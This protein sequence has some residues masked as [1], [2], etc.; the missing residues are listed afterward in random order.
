MFF[1]LNVPIPNLQASGLTATA[2]QSKKGKQAAKQTHAQQS[3]FSF[4][5][6]QVAAIENRVELLV[7]RPSRVCRVSLALTQ[8]KMQLDTR[9]LRLIKPYTRNSTPKPIRTLLKHS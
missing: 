2:T 7:H 5:P 9:S 1:D 4:S 3:E 8:M 6:V